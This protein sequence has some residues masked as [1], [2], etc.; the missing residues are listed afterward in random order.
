M[1]SRSV[2]V[3]RRQGGVTQCLC[4][5]E[6]ERR[7]REVTRSLCE[8][9]GGVGKREGEGFYMVVLRGRF[10]EPLKERVVR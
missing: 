9:G 10:A 5:G 1:V 7:Q 3:G 8:G 4:G 2:S 6:D